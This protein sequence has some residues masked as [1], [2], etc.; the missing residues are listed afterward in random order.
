MK[1]KVLKSIVESFYLIAALVATVLSM[2]V[3]LFG[4]SFYFGIPIILGCGTYM[5]FSCYW[6]LRISKKEG[7]WVL[8]LGI[9]Y[10]FLAV[11]SGIL[12]VT[13][14]ITNWR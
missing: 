8:P 5:F 6:T 12:C 14:C 4:E 13:S 2:L 11:L 10:F 9:L 1:Q 3:F 7:A